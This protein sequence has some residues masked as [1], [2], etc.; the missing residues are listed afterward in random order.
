MIISKVHEKSTSVNSNTVNTDNN[1]H[2]VTFRI[3]SKLNVSPAHASAVYVIM[4]YIVHFAPIDDDDSL[5][6]K[7]IFDYILISRPTASYTV[8]V[9]WIT[10]HLIMHADSQIVIFTSSTN[11]RQ[12]C[13]RKKKQEMV[14]FR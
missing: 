8:S 4:F 2:P 13:K 11:R 14:E 10:P 12:Q 5:L 7:F 9:L 3:R 1:L 6:Y